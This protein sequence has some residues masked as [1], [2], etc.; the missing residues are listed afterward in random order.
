MTINEGIMYNASR[1]KNEVMSIRTP[2]EQKNRGLVLLGFF[3]LLLLIIAVQP[4]ANVVGGY[5]CSDGNEK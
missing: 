2:S 3:M 5:T 1:Q 4:F